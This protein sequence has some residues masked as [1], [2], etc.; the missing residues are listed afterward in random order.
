MPSFSKVIQVGH[1]VHTPE[2]KQVGDSSV[3]KFSIATNYKYGDKEEVC[4][5]DV[6]FWGKQAETICEYVNKGDPILVEG[7]LRQQHWEGQDG[8]KRSKHLIRGDRFAFLPRAERQEGDAPQR[9][10]RQEQQRSSRAA[11]AAQASAPADDDGYD[12]DI[13]F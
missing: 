5:V 11:P 9:E 13:P 1:V 3:V 7:S 10:E 6:E 8:T 4:F 2:V 12:D